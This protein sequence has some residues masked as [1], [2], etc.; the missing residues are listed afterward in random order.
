MSNTASATAAATPTLTPQQ[1]ADFHCDGF[2]ALDQ[3]VPTDEITTLRDFYDEHILSGKL[4]RTI[5]PEE[6]SAIKDLQFRENAKAVIQQLF[7]GRLE[8]QGE[9]FLYR[10]P[11]ETIGTPWHQDA[12]WGHPEW[13]NLSVNLWIPLQDVDATSG[14][15]HFIRGSHRHGHM[16][17]HQ[18]I[19]QDPG[20]NGYV[21]GQAD[22]DFVPTE[23]EVPCP[24]P[25]GGCT[26]HDG[27]TLH[28]SSP[29]QG[30]EPRRAYIISFRPACDTGATRCPPQH[31][32]QI[33][34]QW[35]WNRDR[36]FYYQGREDAGAPVDSG[37]Y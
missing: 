29:N 17:P 21:N 30:T 25:A 31:G 19:P 14:C 18:F 34:Q 28:R 6:H 7:A 8:Y 13:H 27:Y 12:S 24:L 20:H 3:L 35:P 2:I 37:T 5:R 36:Q 4:K 1:V 11:G 32:V 10:L 26:I 23:Y 33:P 15:M 9:K 22:P 16:Y